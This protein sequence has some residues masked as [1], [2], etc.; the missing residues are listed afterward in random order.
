MRKRCIRR[1]WPTTQDTVRLAIE[2]AAI[3]SDS[4]L[5]RIR[6]AE[7]GAIESFVRGRATVDDWVTLTGMT[8]VCETMAR[9]G[10]GHEALPVCQA[11]EQA[12]IQAA[13]RYESTRVFGLTATGLTAL[14]DVFGYHDLQRQSISRGE[15]ERWL[16]K[17]RSRI[18]S[19]APGVADL[20]LIHI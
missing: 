3:T 6:I 18:A 14:R 8:N 7:L 11:A 19:K 2:G 4:I 15:F 17:T 9:G 5:D 10:I 20:S 12:L 13:K 16:D 1:I